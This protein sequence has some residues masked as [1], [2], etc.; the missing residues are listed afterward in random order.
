MLF[1][2]IVF[3]LFCL[4]AGP[5]A[6]Q[7]YLERV[8]KS[9]EIGNEEQLHQIILLD[10]TKALGVALSIDATSVQFRLRDTD[11]VVNF[12]TGLLRYLGRFDPATGGR[13]GGRSASPEPRFVFTDMT[14]EP[15]ALPFA[16]RG[17]VK[18]ID[19]L[20]NVVEFNLNDHVQVGAG[21]AGPLGV[22]ATQRLRTSLSP[23]VH[24]GLSNKLLYI[25]AVGTFN[26]RPPVYGDVHAMLTVGNGRRFVNLGAGRLYDNSFGEGAW[27]YRLGAGARLSDRWTIYTEALAIAISGDFFQTRNLILL[28]TVNAAVRIRRHRWNFGLA[29]VQET[30]RRY[31]PP[32]IPYVGYAYYW[33]TD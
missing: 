27:G 8:H 30:F 5:L 14:Y 4:F 10:Y 31:F 6:A 12:P 19:L 21:I 25:P 23:L 3:V 18:T 29:S 22:L 20:Y 26:S 28:P 15:T 11:E 7:D 32:P 33:G 2:C 16:S 9:V 17:H 1:R 13:G 24:V